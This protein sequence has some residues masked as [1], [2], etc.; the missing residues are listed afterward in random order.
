MAMEVCALALCGGKF[1]CETYIEVGKIERLMPDF[2][3]R[4]SAG[5]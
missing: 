1:N 5:N 2:G 3:N 4:L